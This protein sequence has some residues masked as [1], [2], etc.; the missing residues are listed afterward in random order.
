MDGGDIQDVVVLVLNG[1][2]FALV[3]VDIGFVQADKLPDAVIDMDNII[4]G[5]EIGEDHL[6]RFSGDGWQTTWLRAAPTEDLA[7]SQKMV[8]FFLS[9]A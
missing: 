3:A 9:K 6:G 4:T 8:G 2:V 1:K 5:L 7:V